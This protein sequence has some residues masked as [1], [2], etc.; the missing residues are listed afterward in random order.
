MPTAGPRVLI[1]DDNDAVCLAHRR[2]LSRAG[3][4]VRVGSTLQEGIDA[5]HDWMP[6]II[7]LDLLMPAHNGFEGVKLFREQAATRAALLVA[8]SGIVTDDERERFRALGFD[9]ILPKP[10]AVAELVQR[11]ASFR[12]SGSA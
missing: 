4:D 3:Y 11:L 9:E 10:L 12:R 5:T 1:V 8:F 7:L 2:V 6:D